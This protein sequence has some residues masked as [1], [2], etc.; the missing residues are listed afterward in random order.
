[1]SKS[2]LRM[3]QRTAYRKNQTGG[4]S[5]TKTA[6]SGGK[7]DVL[8]PGSPTRVISAA[9]GDFDEE[10]VRGHLD[11]RRHDRTAI[12]RAAK[13]GIMAGGMAT[14][15]RQCRLFGC[16]PCEAVRYRTSEPANDLGP[17]VFVSSAQRLSVGLQR[18]RFSSRIARLTQF[19][20]SSIRYDGGLYVPGA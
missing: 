11:G 19:D 6:S 13:P 16:G 9:Y 20:G 7:L 3:I 18:P 15:V 10:P 14:V 12:R 8:A 5:S 17:E 1:L 2:W 4:I